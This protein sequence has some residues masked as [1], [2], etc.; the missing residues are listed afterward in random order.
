MVPPKRKQKA[1]RKQ[2]LEKIEEFNEIDLFKELKSRDP[3]RSNLIKEMEEL[4]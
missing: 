4:W 1:S 3:L 2:A